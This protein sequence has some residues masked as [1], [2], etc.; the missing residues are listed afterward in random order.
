MDSFDAGVVAGMEKVALKTSTMASAAKK[1]GI[2]IHQ[3]RQYA[4]ARMENA[5]IM[6]SVGQK[7]TPKG[8]RPGTYTAFRS[9]MDAPPPRKG[10]GSGLDYA[11]SWMSNKPKMQ[12]AYEKWKKYSDNW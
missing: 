6:K 10:A 8:P 2:D 4:Q 7:L 1:R 12:K 11:R 9:I 5:R 3:L